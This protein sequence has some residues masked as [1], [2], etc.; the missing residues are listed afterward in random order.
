MMLGPLRRLWRALVRSALATDT[1]GV[2]MVEYGLLVAIVAVTA[3][4]SFSMVSNA[5]QNALNAAQQNIA[6]N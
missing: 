4:A 1:D 5:L 3:M 2:T 6:K